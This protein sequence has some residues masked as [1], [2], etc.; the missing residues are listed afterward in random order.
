MWLVHRME[1]KQN[2]TTNR[3]SGDDSHY[4]QFAKEF[5]RRTSSEDPT[6]VA[7]VVVELHRKGIEG[8]CLHP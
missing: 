6:L 7:A 8:G 2:K 4:L 5:F 3:D 1:L